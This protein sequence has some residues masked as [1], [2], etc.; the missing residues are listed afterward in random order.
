MT[1][2]TLLVIAAVVMLTGISK[3]GFAGALG[4]FA[5][6]L[7]LLVMP[8][9]DAI[10]LM[11]PILIIADVF[12]L[13]S[14]WRQWQNELIRLLLPGVVVGVLIAQWLIQIIPA[15][16][17]S[18]A[19]ATLSLLF[20]LRSLFFAKIRYGFLASDW[21]GRVMATLSGLA[22]TLVHAGGPPLII[23]FTAKALAPRQ[24]VATAAALFALMNGVK[25]A[26]FSAQGLLTLDLLF[27]A[28]AFVPLAL[29]GNWLGVK[30]QQ[31]F[32]P[33]HFLRVMNWLLLLLALVL[34]AKLML[35]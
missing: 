17:L 3:S 6:P 15:A 25:L 23:Y 9:L 1:L 13:K 35:S 24:Y 7:L 21:G 14:Y 10:A 20:A 33:Q 27:S 11:L 28:L 31:K 18:A 5:V 32:N 29:L 2:T 16:W 4:V 12:S 22:S 30:I 34:Y 8:A 19:I 26:A